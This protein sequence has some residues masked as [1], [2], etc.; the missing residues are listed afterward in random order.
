MIGDHHD[1][2]TSSDY[3]Q[4]MC[5]LELCNSR[6]TIASC[7]FCNILPTCINK[8]W[9]NYLLESKLKKHIMKIIY[10]SVEMIYRED[11]GSSFHLNID[12]GLPDYT[13]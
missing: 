8:I 9:N 5:K 4:P 3:H 7:N 10:Y 2:R 12:N 13:S 1:T 6:P 11:G